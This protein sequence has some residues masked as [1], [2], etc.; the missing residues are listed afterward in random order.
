M[1]CLDKVVTLGWLSYLRYDYELALNKPPL[2]LNN[3]TGFSF[4]SYVLNLDFPNYI[5]Q[6]IRRKFLNIRMPANQ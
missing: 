2:Y 3:F 1:F 5:P 6:A 4:V